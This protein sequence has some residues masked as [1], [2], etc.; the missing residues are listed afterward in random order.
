MKKL[1]K[2]IGR[3]VRLFTLVMTLILLAS[4]MPLTLRAMAIETDVNIEE[5][6]EYREE[7]SKHF[8]MP[9]GTY[10]AVSYTA[11][12]HRMDENGEWQD[13]ENILSENTVKNKQAYVTSDG[14]TVFSKKIS[15]DDRTVFEI[16]DGGYSMKVSFEN[17]DIKN[18]NAKLSN[19]A[20]KYQP[21]NTDDIE[22]QYKKLKE[23]DTNT[24][25]K[26]K[27]IIKNIDLEYIL[28][29]ND[30]KE[31]IIIRKAC[32]D[33]E[34]SFIY[35]FEGLSA[36]LCEDGSVEIYDSETNEV[37]YSIPAPYMYDD[38]GVESTDVT[39]SL[40]DLGDGRYR[41]TV[42]PDKTWINAENRAF[43]VIVDPTVTL[44]A[45]L[46]DTYIS[47][48][49]PTETFGSAE[50]LWISQNHIVFMKSSS[51]LPTLPEDSKVTEAILNVRYY[52]NISS[53][54]LSVGL[55]PV[56]FSWGTSSLTWNSASQHTNM[57][58]ESDRA[59]SAA[60]FA[61]SNITSDSPGN[62][63]FDV[64]KLVRRWYAGDYMYGIALKYITGTNTSVIIKSTECGTGTRAYYD[65]TYTLYTP[66]FS[67]GVYYIE[68]VE[69]GRYID[70]EGPSTSYGA[71]IQQW[72]C[73]TGISERWELDNIEGVEN[74]VRLKSTLSNLFLG[75]DPDNPSLIKQYSEHRLNTAWKLEQTYDGN[76]KLVSQAAISGG[77]V[78]AV[79]LNANSNGT[80]LT[81]IS[82]SDDFNY[83][84][85]WDFQRILPTNGYELAYSPSSWSGYV[86]NCCNCYAYALNNQVY[87][88]TNLLW[89]KQQMGYYKGANYQYSALTETNIYTAVVNDYSAYNEDFDTSL[90]FQRIG[91]YD[92]CPAGTYKVALVVSEGD[93]HWYRQDADGLWSHKR[94]L[95][96]VERTDY[97]GKLIIDPCIADRG[98]YTQFLGYYAVTPWS[99]SFTANGTVYCYI[100]GYMIT[101]AELMDYLE[102]MQSVQTPAS[103]FYL[104]VEDKAFIATRTSARIY[105]DG[106]EAMK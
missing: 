48:N 14:R 7:Y 94:G 10:K 25:V 80:D 71:I 41:L 68:N 2:G 99:K 24:T 74:C 64:T 11:P 82:Y 55:H 26:Y 88:N 46:W 53:G 47:K 75:V 52:Y 17:E 4:S 45:N 28:S 97:S 58:M 16:N 49:R 91:R 105:E 62:M 33:Y 86:Q 12:V 106:K 92:V 98:D 72:D 39:Y 73:H 76:Y 65:I 18:S 104:D 84:D 8:K 96:P 36:M 22:T 51:M 78:L 95:N 34:F 85:E 6:E 54:S 69:T 57:G 102:S 38:D 35:E 63:Y 44:H 42:T 43:P 87:P 100:E 56:T 90:T 19:H 20:K 13:L 59:S 66:D 70:V 31:N 23:I 103:S 29:A 77:K 93:Y 81:Q 60:A 89:F 79:P 67:D 1:N 3:S 9:D 27:N 61:A 21:T 83:R 37:K 30:I 50:D 101:Y 15:A 5:V 32:D 40:D